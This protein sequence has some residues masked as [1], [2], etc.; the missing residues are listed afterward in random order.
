MGIFMF[1]V[2]PILATSAA[3]AAP[4]MYIYRDFSAL[5]E[6]IGDFFANLM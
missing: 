6:R 2:A 4:F 1:I 3:I 5:F